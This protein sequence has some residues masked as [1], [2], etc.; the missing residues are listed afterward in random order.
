VALVQFGRN[1]KDSFEGYQVVAL[2]RWT[3]FKVFYIPKNP[4]SRTPMKNFPGPFCSPRLYKYNL[5]A[6]QI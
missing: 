6:P 3:V 1:R 4:L 2:D 5:L